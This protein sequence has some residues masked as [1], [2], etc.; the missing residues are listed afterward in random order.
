MSVGIIIEISLNNKLCKLNL[1][2][3]VQ[4]LMHVSL[5]QVL[6]LFAPF[7]QQLR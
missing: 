6:H 4:I 5:L 3:I 2:D 7:S 1:L